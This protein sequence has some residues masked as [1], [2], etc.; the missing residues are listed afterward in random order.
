MSYNLILYQELTR[1]YDIRATLRGSL[2]PFYLLRI[3]ILVKK[4][5]AISLIDYLNL[6]IFYY[7]F[8][9]SQI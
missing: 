5:A 8:L 3:E 1:V 7:I 2:Y 6:T 9:A 4:A